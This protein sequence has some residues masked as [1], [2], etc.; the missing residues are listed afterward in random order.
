M[1]RSGVL[2]PT[3]L[4]N[5]C[6]YSG[7]CGAGA[8][9]SGLQNN[10]IKKKKI[11]EKHCAVCATR[12]P[13]KLSLWKRSPNVRLQPSKTFRLRFRAPCRTRTA[14]PEEQFEQMAPEPRWC[15][16]R[17]NRFIRPDTT[18]AY[19]DC[20]PQP[21]DQ[22]ILLTLCFYSS[23]SFR[24]HLRYRR[25][26]Q[27]PLGGAVAPSCVARRH[28]D[29][30]QRRV[31]VFAKK[32]FRVGDADEEDVGYVREGSGGF[33]AVIICGCVVETASLKLSE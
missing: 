26:V 20:L 17:R 3:V 1:Y 21:G 33:L 30:I 31:P 6:R 7:G 11:R 23:S 19:V 18:R 25:G 13:Q 14:L 15:L 8:Q 16:F 28:C 5:N 22:N 4:K 24:S 29:V 10:L 12:L 32:R 9:I 2:V 27:R